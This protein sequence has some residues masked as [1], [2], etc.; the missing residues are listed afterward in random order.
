M[1]TNYQMADLRR[2]INGGRSRLTNRIFLRK[3]AT[4]NLLNSCIAKRAVTPRC[5]VR[6]RHRLEHS[7][8][9]VSTMLKINGGHEESP[10][11][12]SAGENASE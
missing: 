11:D 1:Q 2:N 10:D 12:L 9:L 5:L 7:P 6:S 4:V 3:R 8:F